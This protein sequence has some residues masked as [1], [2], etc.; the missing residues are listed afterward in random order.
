MGS[1]ESEAYGSITNTYKNMFIPIL[2]VACLLMI[3][4]DNG[5]RIDTSWRKTNI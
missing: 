2:M 1:F 5:V 3:S 4:G